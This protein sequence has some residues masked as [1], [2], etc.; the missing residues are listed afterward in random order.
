M[1][2]ILTFNKK[3]LDFIE[4]IET[5]T[6]SEFK[7]A[8]GTKETEEEIFCETLA[9][10]NE[11]QINLRQFKPIS[12]LTH[13]IYGYNEL[14]IID[15]KTDEVTENILFCQYDIEEKKVF[16]VKDKN[17]NEWFRIRLKSTEPMET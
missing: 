7:R 14:E 2:H 3:Q 4:D 10:T 9:E 5:M 1:E 11:Y 15:K 12:H 17:H 13:P 6:P 16:T 8:Y